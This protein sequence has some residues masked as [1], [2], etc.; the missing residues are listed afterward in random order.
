[1][2]TAT[3]AEFL[4]RLLGEGRV[5]FRGPPMASATGDDRAAAVVILRT[6]FAEDLMELAGPPLPFDEKTAIAAAEWTRR[7]CWF[8][9]SRGEPTEVVDRA[10]GGFPM[11]R[12]A[13]AH[14]AADLTFRYLPA[15]RRRA[16]AIDPDDVLS[17]RLDEVLRRWPLSGVL[18]DLDASPESPTDFDGHEGLLLRFSERLI[19]HERRSWAPGSPLG[20]EILALALEAAG[21]PRSALLGPDTRDLE[22]TNDPKHERQPPGRAGARAGGTDGGRG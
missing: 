22:G 4:E 21:R 7:A 18:A 5:A 19:D 17:R 1:M 11:P 8:L 13:S 9:I 12:D 2:V 3:L 14:L 15:L 16:R 6:A 10:L 20:R